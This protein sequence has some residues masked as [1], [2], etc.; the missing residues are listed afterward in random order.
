M[1]GILGYRRGGGSDLD[2]DHAAVGQFDEDIDLPA[3][4][5]VSDVEEPGREVADS[6]VG[7]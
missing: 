5:G 6:A 3:A 1:P 7:A 4:I 2:A